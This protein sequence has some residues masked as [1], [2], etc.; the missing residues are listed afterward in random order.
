ME[1]FK[2]GLSP[3]QVDQGHR[4]KRPDLVMKWLAACLSSPSGFLCISSVLLGQ[5]A[6]RTG[7]IRREYTDDTNTTRPS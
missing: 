1:L 4:P 3:A 5:E 7:G 6:G 2:A